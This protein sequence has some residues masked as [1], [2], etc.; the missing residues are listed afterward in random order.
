MLAFHGIGQDHRC[1]LPLA[2]VLKDQYT[3]YLLDLPFHGQS[4][5]LQTE[6][7]TMEAWKASLELFLNE[8]NITTFSVVGFSMGGKFALG[9]VQ[10]FPKQI[11]SCWLLAPDGITESPWYRLATRFWFTKFFFRIFISNAGNIKKLAYPLLKLNLVER[12]TVKFAESTLA[13]AAQRERV[14]R[15]WVGFS[16]IRPDMAAVAQI[17]GQNHIH[18]KL[19]LGQFDTLLPISYVKPLTQRLPDVKPI[20]LKTGHHRLIEKVAEWF[21]QNP[22]GPSKTL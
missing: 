7:L 10:L 21:G 12:S 9:T 16:A 5:P 1:F 4:L 8:N 6:K 18:L 20:L 22:V 17:V 15:S 2:E 19:F 11:E 3:F 14:Y 13:N